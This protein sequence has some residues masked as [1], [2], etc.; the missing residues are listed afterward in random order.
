LEL[1]E[2]DGDG[3]TGFGVHCGIGLKKPLA[4]GAS[5]DKTAL[6]WVAPEPLAVVATAGLPELALM[7][8]LFMI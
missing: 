1:D 4:V 7:A 8:E 5:S 3:L 6:E 2:L